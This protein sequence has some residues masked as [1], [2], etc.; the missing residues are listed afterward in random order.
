[1]F[2]LTIGS[3]PSVAQNKE[4]KPLAGILSVLE[5]QFDVVFTYADENVEGIVVA[6]PNKE[7]S[8]EECLGELE[9]QTRLSFI[10]LNARYIAIVKSMHD[11][12]VSGLLIDQSTKEHIARA[13]VYS[14]NSYA[15]SDENGYF[16]IKVN[17]ETDSVLMVRH[18]GYKPL[19]LDQSIWSND[20]SIYELTPDVQVLEEVVVN[21]IAKGLDKLPDGSI[22]LHTQNLEVLPGLAEPDVLRA[23]QVLPGIQSVNETVSNINTRGGTNDQ[24]LVLW[25]GVKMY[26]TGHFFGL[27]S[28]FNS[29]LIHKARIVKNGTSAAFDEGISGIIDMKQQDYPVN[30]T[31]ISTGFNMVSA[32]MILKTPVSKKLSLIMGARHSISNLVLTPTYKSYYKRAFEHTEVLLDQ[33][34]TD[35]TVDDYRD[36][37]FYDLSCKFLYD[38]SEKDKIRLSLLHVNNSIEYEESALVRDTLYN[39]KSHLGQSSRLVNLNY[40]RSWNENHV[41]QFSTFVSNYNLDGTN[42]SLAD[43]QHHLQKNEVIDLGVKLD[44][45]NKINQTIALSGGYQFREVGIRNQDNIRK[46]DYY[47][48][49][50]DVLRIHSLYAE[51]EVKE[52]FPKLYLRAGL[53]TNYYSKF[54]EFSVEPRAVINYRWS[55]YFSLEAQAEKK[56]QY[57]TQQIDYQTDFLGIENRRWVLSNNQSVPLLKC[58]QFSI[59]MQ[60][61]RKTFLVSL[62]GYTKKVNGIISPSQGFQNQ[63][64]YVYG[65]GEYNAQG[66]ELLVNKR[67]KQSNFWMNYALTQNEYYFQEFIPPA[68]P[69]TLI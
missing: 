68:F 35:K 63:F 62:E 10:K 69:I 46:P 20:S 38:V 29:H 22:Q 47:R 36:F 31:E 13:V 16:S 32:D 21:Y 14:E 39:K 30:R 3:K 1:M 19:H 7:A 9:K 42:V 18:T 45:K 56:S 52:L 23:V 65:I 54:N 17:T 12:M 5:K 27:V 57:T 41:T 59:G 64:Q 37:S 48:D 24:S 11:I 15:L 28:A 34:G 58:H 40:T 67:F 60:Y 6:F 8:L 49:V 61:N 51:A 2:I 66:I 55:K 33:K 26:Q 53:R 44:T 4:T 50:K 25:D 43:N